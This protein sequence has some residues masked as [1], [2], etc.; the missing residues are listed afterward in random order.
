MRLLVLVELLLLLLL[1]M[2]VRL[3]LIV[4]V[5]VALMVIQIH[6]VD[7]L[8]GHGALVQH[9]HALPILGRSLVMRHHFPHGCNRRMVSAAAACALPCLELQSRCWCVGPAWR[10]LLR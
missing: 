4:L 9:S 2:L 6:T 10:R 1:V 7:T 3:L 5:T 8:S